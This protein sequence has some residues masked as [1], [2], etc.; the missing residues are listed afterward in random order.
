MKK[1]AKK[2][3][4]SKYEYRLNILLTT[5]MAEQIKDKYPE[6]TVASIIRT[7]LKEFLEK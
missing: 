4:N 1:M 2:L 7:A 3:K 6:M 5:E